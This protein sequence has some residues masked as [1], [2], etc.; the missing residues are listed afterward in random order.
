M[1]ELTLS[2]LDQSPVREGGTAAQALHE[3]IELARAAEGLGYQRYWVAEHHSTAM[4]AGTAPEVLI[5]Q[6]AANT[7]SIRVGSGGVMLSHYSAL[8]VAEA[9]R[10]LSAFYPGRIDLGIG[11]APGSDQRTALALVDPRPLADVNQ[12]PR[13]V[14]DLLG[15]L[16]NELPEDHPFAEVA[17]Q[18]GPLPPG[19]PEVWLLGSSDFSARLAALLGLPFAFADFFGNAGDLGPRVAELYRQQ[20]RPSESLQA[21]RLSAAVHVICAETEERARFVASSTKLR[22]AQM[23]SGAHPSGLLPPEEAS[24]YTSHAATSHLIQA[25]TRHY[26]EGN[27][28]MVREQ[29]LAAAGRYGT[30]D[31]II[32]TNCYAFADR[33]HSYELVARVMGLMPPAGARRA[34]PDPVALR[35]EASPGP[36]ETS[37][38]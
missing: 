20:F 5:G 10:V 6:I 3:T 19:L 33:V 9:F 37:G 26:V 30:D 11:R 4:F 28:E 25:F 17:A 16:A 12:F 18:P 21:P 36:P 1:P 31:L 32:A 22:V 23:R 24:Q 8:K 7:S 38:E 27:P 13:Q 29:L 35:V 15:F 2:V 14:A 34:D